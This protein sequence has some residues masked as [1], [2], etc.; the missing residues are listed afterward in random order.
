MH[1]VEV[2]FNVMRPWELQQIRAAGFSRSESE[3]VV[4]KLFGT[5]SV[6]EMYPKDAEWS[7]ETRNTAQRL[8]NRCY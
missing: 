7:A 2:R 8:A 3:C 4:G 5:F 1:P 6:T